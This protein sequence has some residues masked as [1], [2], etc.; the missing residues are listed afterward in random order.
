[1]SWSRSWASGGGRSSFCSAAATAVLLLALIGC[2]KPVPP[3]PSPGEAALDRVLVLAGRDRASLELPRAAEAGY[4]VPTSYPFIDALLARPL[5]LPVQAERLGVALDGAATPSEVLAALRIASP[6]GP[7]IV[8]LVDGP[9]EA[10]FVPSLPTPTQAVSSE[11]GSLLVSHLPAAFTTQLVDLVRELEQADRRWSAVHS[12]LTPPDRAAE[13]YFVEAFGGG[14]RFRSHPVGVQ[15]EFLAAAEGL[16]QAAMM[17]IASQLS[18]GVERILPALREAALELP[19]SSGYLLHLETSLGPIVVGST[20]ADVHEEDAFLLIDPGGDD[21][22]GNNAGGNVGVP[23]SVA[24]AIDL[25][26]RDKYTSGR[27][28]VQGAGYA[29]VG[30]LIDLGAEPD[31]YL[32]ASQSQGAGFFGVGILWDEGGDDARQALASS[33]GFGT[34]GVGLLLD[35]AGNDRSAVQARGQG[36]GSTAGLGIHADLAG[37]DQSRLGVA[38]EDING[39]MGGGG[40][41]GGMGTRPFP[42]VGDASLH[43]G[44]GLLYDRAGTD[45]Y[46]ARADGQGSGWMLGIG[47]LLDRSGDDRYVAEHRGQGSATHLAAGVLVDGGGADSYEGTNTVQGAAV[48]RSIGVLWDRGDAAD[49]YAV[50]PTGAALP[51]ELGGGQAWAR[52]ARALALLVDDGGDDRYRPGFDGLGFVVPPARPDR[53]S[54]AAIID[55][56]G[57]DDYLLAMRRP[58][59]NPADGATWLHEDRG[60]GMDLFEARPGW[61][62]EPLDPAGLAGF[63]WSGE[64]APSAPPPEPLDGDPDGDSSARWLAAEA[65]YRDAA[66]G[67]AFAVP[68]WIRTAALADPSP[69]VRRAAARVLAASGELEGV[70]VLVDSLVYQSEDNWDRPSM[71][72]VRLWLHLLTDLEVG[73]DAEQW[74][75]QWRAIRPGFDLEARWGPLAGFERAQRASAR[76]DTVGVVTACSEALSLPEG[77]AVRRPC[78]TLVGLWAWLLGHPESHVNH[79]PARAVELGQ[80]AVQWAPDHAEHF[81]HLARAF[82]L[83]G[84]PDLAQRSLAKAEVLD[85]DGEELIKLRREMEEGG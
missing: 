48:D 59:A 7:A 24:L 12:E 62:H 74:R 20:G 70:D 54:T 32:A 63:S 78:A 8:E 17:E 53:D 23:S 27:D 30:M 47:L 41:G 66:H 64:V 16:D 6:G 28:H 42:W 50:Q 69:P 38:G 26:G 84:Q 85:P 72:S 14:L 75:R 45:G 60:I 15:L 77:R 3:D 21:R 31:D 22:W 1:M 43:G 58:G 76:R 29:G 61:D 39:P 82:W 40:Q 52:K 67:V 2:P 13:E 44:V 80:L 9:V 56:G 83:T 49:T 51:R 25:G 36:F 5:S 79:D 10:G 35:G 34:F 55:L 19:G 46:Y 11:R 68:E 73:G 37:A 4:F 81:V 18:A 65:L 71:D 57:T 33:Q